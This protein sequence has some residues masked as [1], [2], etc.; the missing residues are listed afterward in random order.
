MKLDVEVE[1]WLKTAHSFVRLRKITSVIERMAQVHLLSPYLSAL[2]VP[3]FILCTFM[4][5][6]TWV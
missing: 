4:M 5:K 2:K 3:H 1:V 6:Q